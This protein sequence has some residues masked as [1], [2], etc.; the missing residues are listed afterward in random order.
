[1]EKDLREA[2]N[3][4]LREWWDYN[5]SQ[6]TEPVDEPDDELVDEPDSEHQFSIVRTAFHGGGVI[7]Y[8]ISEESAKQHI[9]SLLAG[10]DCTCGCYG[11]CPVGE[12]EGL[13]VGDGKQHSPY[14]LMM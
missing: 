4:A 1:V 3:S 14:S 12:L 11:V 8:A 9:A 13:P 2:A 7:G 6:W 10:C 5:G